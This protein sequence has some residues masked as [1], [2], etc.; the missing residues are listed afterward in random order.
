MKAAPV[1]HAAT[2]NHT[3]VEPNTAKNQGPKTS[4][5]YHTTDLPNRFNDPSAYRDICNQNERAN[6]CHINKL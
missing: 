2:A 1:A 6:T 3:R 5:F 4:D